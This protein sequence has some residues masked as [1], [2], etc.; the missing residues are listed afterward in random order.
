[1]ISM[2]LSRKVVASGEIAVG[3]TCGTVFLPAR[4]MAGLRKSNEH[5]RTRGRWFMAEKA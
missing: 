1:M 4:P 5:A 2:A 3:L